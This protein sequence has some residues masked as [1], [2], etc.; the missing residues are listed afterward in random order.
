[1]NLEA[2][3]EDRVRQY[4]AESVRSLHRDRGGVLAASGGGDSTAMIALLCQ[5]AIVEPARC[6]VA[7]FDHRLRGATAADGDRRVVEALCARYGLQLVAGRWESPR[8]GE[9]A[10]REAR[11]AFLADA[12]RSSG[13]GVVMTGHTADDHVETVLMNVM[14]GARVYGLA[15]MSPEGNAPVGAAGRNRV[16]LARPLLCVRRD[17]TRAYCEQRG[18]TF[19]DD[20][21]NE[22]ESLLR[23][24]VRRQLLPAIER[25]WPD[26]RET[27]LKA[28]VRAWL[29]VSVLDGVAAR[30]IVE[31]REDRVALSRLALRELSAAAR[32]HAF[33]LA[34][35]HLL[36]DAREFG[37]EHYATM[38][39]GID[40]RTG[41]TFSLPRHVE[42]V[43]D[44]EAVM[45]SVGQLPVAALPPDYERQLP[46]RGSVGNWWVEVIPAA[47]SSDA[48]A[49]DGGRVD[50]RLPPDALIRGWRPGDRLQPDGMIGHKKLQDYYTDRKVPRRERHAAP[51]IATS[52]QDV[53][54]TPFGP[55]A[56]L[57]VDADGVEWRVRW[58]RVEGGEVGCCPSR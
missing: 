45:L 8:R 53:A 25:G 12:C 56:A 27:L 16:N 42:M 14:R 30:A 58:H 5:A 55:V 57:P 52:G 20:A 36:G 9:A 17:E 46:F 35:T 31:Q 24:R 29:A 39:D 37:Q 26:A 10:A 18:M 50:L 23:N 4:V 19:A 44:A 38:Q 43:V 54:W 1:V 22:D 21:S 13:L 6:V 51:V 3:L 28:S 7:H 11:Y 40:G 33:R 48:G 32:G 41:A 49:L 34:L 47:S 15:G 2:L